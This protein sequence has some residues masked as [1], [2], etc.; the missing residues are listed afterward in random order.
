VFAYSAEATSSK[1]VY[2]SLINGNN[3]SF[4]ELSHDKLAQSLAAGLHKLGLMNAKLYEEYKTFLEKAAR[5]RDERFAISNLV[6]S[7]AGLGIPMP[8]EACAIYVKA[9]PKAEKGEAVEITSYRNSVKA[10]SAKS[11]KEK[12]RA[13]LGDR[14]A[15][16]G[17]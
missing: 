6:D 7:L 5:E 14:I 8:I 13:S 9:F 10:A 1:I 11:A 4:N 2:T 15:A 16:E 3:F 17:T 12:K